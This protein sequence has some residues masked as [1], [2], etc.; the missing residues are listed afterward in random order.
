[1]SMGCDQKGGLF[2][3]NKRTTLSKLWKDKPKSVILTEI[4]ELFIYTGAFNYLHYGIT[5]MEALYHYIDVVPLSTDRLI[6]DKYYNIFYRLE[7]ES[8]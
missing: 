7:V 4:L 1:M 3:W 8:A 5:A 6:K 2:L